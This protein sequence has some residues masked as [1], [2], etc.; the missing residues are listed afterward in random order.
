MS[1]LSIVFQNRLTRILENF[2]KCH[3]NNMEVT[4]KLGSSIAHL[5]MVTH[6]VIVTCARNQLLS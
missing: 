1:N 6:F 5:A 4:I 2:T 3:L